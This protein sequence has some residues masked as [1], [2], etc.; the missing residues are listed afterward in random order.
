M[1]LSDVL[2]DYDGTTLDTSR[3]MA[4]AV[5]LSMLLFQGVAVFHSRTFDAQAF[6]VGMGG[7]L[8]GL[9]IAIGG[10]NHHRP[11]ANG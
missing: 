2:T 10:D 7:I 9:G 5:I 3:C 1:K 6:G 11:G 4:V 8:A